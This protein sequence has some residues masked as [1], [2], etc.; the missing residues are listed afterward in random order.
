MALIKVQT[1]DFD[2]GAIIDSMHRTNPGVGAV[3]SFV[4]VVR[5]LNDDAE[6][7]QLTL[8]HYPGMTERALER[9]ADEACERW[10]LQD[11]AIVHRV[12]TLGPTDRIVL[13]VT[14]SAHR[15]HAF[16]AC[17]FI[18]DFL[19]TKAPLWKKEATPQGERWV[20][21]RES[22]AEAARRWAPA[23]DAGKGP[24]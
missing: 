20:D 9:I 24:E 8:E 17:R 19:K 18:M 15:H 13:V 22:D 21:S 14:A 1:E 4:G 3:A 10:E 7:G 11:L 2:V 5:D 12:G 23:G 6:V 16:D